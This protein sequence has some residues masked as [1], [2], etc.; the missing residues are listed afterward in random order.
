MKI[1]F[2]WGFVW[3]RGALKRR[4]CRFPAPRAAACLVHYLLL[5]KVTSPRFT[6]LNGLRPGQ[7]RPSS[8]ARGRTRTSCASSAP[9]IITTRTAHSKALMVRG[10][11]WDDNTALSRSASLASARACRARTPGPPQPC[12]TLSFRLKMI[13]RLVYKALRN[14]RQWQPM[15]AQCRMT[16]SPAA[17]PP[18]AAPRWWPSSPRTATWAPCSRP[19]RRAAG[20]RRRRGSRSRRRSE[21][22]GPPA[23]HGHIR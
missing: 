20:C 9:V 2:V 14:D 8:A 22:V 21:L 1:H 17:R 4:K 16:V 6:A 5:Q 10:T 12:A 3:A 13:A 11:G 19:R 15:A 23:S 7:R 18:R